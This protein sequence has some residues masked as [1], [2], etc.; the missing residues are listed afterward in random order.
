MDST[1][2]RMWGLAD[3]H[4]LSSGN[5]SS[6]RAV[7]L[8]LHGGFTV[9]DIPRLLIHRVRPLRVPPYL[10]NTSPLAPS[11]PILC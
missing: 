4:T 9:G 11:T 2:E 7:V 1:R 8:Y 6:T 3:S 10:G 5:A